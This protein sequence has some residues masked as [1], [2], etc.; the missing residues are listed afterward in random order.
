MYFVEIPTHSAA[1][2]KRCCTTLAVGYDVVNGLGGCLGRVDLHGAICS[3]VD[4]GGDAEVEVR[5]QAKV[6]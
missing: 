2:R 6:L 1:R 4:E 5:L 3:S